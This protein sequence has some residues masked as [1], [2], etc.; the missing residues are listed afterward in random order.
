MCNSYCTSYISDLLIMPFILCLG[1]CQRS[2]LP[3]HAF[4]IVYAF[5]SHTLCVLIW[6]ISPSCSPLPNTSLLCPLV[7]LVLMWM[8]FCC[9]AG[10]C[11]TH[12]KRCQVFDLW[13]KPR[14]F[15]L[16]AQKYCLKQGDKKLINVMSEEHSRGCLTSTVHS[17]ALF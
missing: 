14:V 3:L 6:P 8:E 17:F 1:L 5:L 16:K 7:T 11:R 9:W 12:C 4:S 10:P 15:Y 2:K 13:Q